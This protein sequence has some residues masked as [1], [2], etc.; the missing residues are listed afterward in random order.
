MRTARVLPLLLCWC[1][2]GL[3]AVV[4][5]AAAPPPTQLCGVCGPSVAND[6]EVAGATDHGTLDVYVDETGNSLWHARIPVTDSAAERYRSNESAL[7]AAVD[8]AWAH[9]HAADGDVRAV[10]ATVEDD[11]VVV[12]YTVDDVARRGVGDSWIIDYFATGTS[13]TRYELAA[14]RLTIHTPDGT[15]ITNRLPAADVDGNE[16]TWTN[17]ND[18]ARDR[19]FDDQTYVTY[20][21]GGLLG[22]ASGYATIAHVTGPPALACGLAIGAVPGALIGLLGIVIG[23]SSR[24]SAVV[25][26]VTSRLGLERPTVDAATLE[27]L[28]VAVGIGGAIGF[29]AYG[30]VATDRVFP[31]AAVVL[32]S[33]GVGYALL[34]LAAARIGPRLE[35]RG[36]F[37]LAVFATLVAAAYTRAL[38][39]GV[40]YALPL[41]FGVATALFLPIGHAFER[42]RRPVALLGAA[43]LVPSAVGALVYP[44]SPIG[45]WTVLVGMLVFLPWVAVVG[46]F[47]YPLAL[48]GRTLAAA[49][50]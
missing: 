31:P 43:A 42:D 23:R 25:E 2:V 50:G 17:E 1:L 34:G 39:G 37:V 33:L 49:D 28:L 22:T 13:S 18:G 24:G 40:V 21:E 12:N 19:G 35:T 44:A 45:V 41:L 26:R 36:L 7:E 20:G 10:E 30:A 32:S 15:V 9:S 27:R 6:A 5:V 46:I 29:L 11:T 8:D 14:E 3:I 16:A 4:A 38:A 48:L 47:G